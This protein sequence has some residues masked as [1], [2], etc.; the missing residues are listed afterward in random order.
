MLRD[1]V[2]A[3]GII[4]ENTAVI[5]LVHIQETRYQAAN[6]RWLALRCH[7]M[8]VRRGVTSRR[9]GENASAKRRERRERRQQRAV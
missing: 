6:S 1:E 9:S 3:C 4:T 8:A 7:M 5:E 2:N